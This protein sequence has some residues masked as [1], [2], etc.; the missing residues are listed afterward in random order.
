M[1]H[2]KN[3]VEKFLGHIANEVKPL[4]ATYPQQPMTEITVVLKKEHE[5]AEK[6]HIC[7]KEFNSEN[8]KRSLSL[9]GFI[10]RSNPQQL[11]SEIS[12]ARPHTHCVLQLKWL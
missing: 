9:Q 3:C 6:C 12:D 10:S 5:A 11:Q 2:G 1:Y 8:R 4:Y 7:F